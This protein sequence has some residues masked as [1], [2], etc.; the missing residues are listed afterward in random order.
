MFKRTQFVA[1]SV[2]LLMALAKSSFSAKAQTQ[3]PTSSDPLLPFLALIPDTPDIRA[4][5]QIASYAN[6]HAAAVGLTLPASAA[7]MSHDQLSAYGHALLRIRTGPD[8]LNYFAVLIGKMPTT[9][10]FDWFDMD[11]TLEYGTPPKLGLILSGNFD[12]AKIGSALAARN[13]QQTQVEG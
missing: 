2:L 11:G 4:P 3:E 12:P 10:G 7:A 6:Y 5:L 8:F 13:F 1:I 9:V